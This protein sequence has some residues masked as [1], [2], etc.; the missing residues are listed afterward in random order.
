M[1]SKCGV[2][3]FFINMN[4]SHLSFGVIAIVEHTQIIDL[5]IKR[6]LTL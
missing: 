6:K 1:K 2:D 5:S 3:F 4:I